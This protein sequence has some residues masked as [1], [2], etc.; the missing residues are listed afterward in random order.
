MIDQC[1]SLVLS[2]WIWLTFFWRSVFVSCNPWTFK[3]LCL[4]QWNR[5]FVDLS[6][7]LCTRL[8]WFLNGSANGIMINFLDL[9]SLFG[10]SSFLLYLPKTYGM[11]DS[12]LWTN[13]VNSA[14]SVYIR[15]FSR[16]FFLQLWP[17][18]IWRIIDRRVFVFDFILKLLF[19]SVFWLHIPTF[20]S[21]VIVY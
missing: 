7:H 11:L 20:M 1:W 10:L 12:S 19:K 13:L 3:I 15:V 14:S 9:N 2:R 16:W 5:L 18:S 6:L 8:F 17:Y 4:A 21:W